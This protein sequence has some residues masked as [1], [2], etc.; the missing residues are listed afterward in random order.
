MR[1]YRELPKLSVALLIRSP[2]RAACD[3][4]LTEMTSA[5][6]RYLGARDSQLCLDHGDAAACP[7]RRRNKLAE[8]FMAAASHPSPAFDFAD[9]TKPSH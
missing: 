6:A 3:E 8:G 9:L 1:S 2:W 4:C 5:H 7:D